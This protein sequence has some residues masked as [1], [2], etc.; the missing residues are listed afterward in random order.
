MA[1][2]EITNLQ[3]PVTAQLAALGSLSFLEPV[4]TPDSPVVPRTRLNIT[5]GTLLGLMLAA[6]G[7]LL[8][9]NLRDTVRFPDQLTRRV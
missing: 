7:A 2:Q 9:N 5:L 8:L 6:G 3:D 4:A 1:S